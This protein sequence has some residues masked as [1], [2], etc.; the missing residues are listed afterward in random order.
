MDIYM[1]L[2]GFVISNR[3]DEIHTVLKHMSFLNTIFK[4]ISITLNG[5]EV[6]FVCGSTSTVSPSLPSVQIPFWFL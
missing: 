3:T 2:M 6:K 5:F 1:G 4:L